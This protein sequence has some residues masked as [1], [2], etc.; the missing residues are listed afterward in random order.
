MFADMSFDPCECFY[1]AA[2]SLLPWSSVEDSTNCE[3][4]SD[5][6]AVRHGVS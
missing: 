1:K 4:C 3:L 5:A 2:A 6:G